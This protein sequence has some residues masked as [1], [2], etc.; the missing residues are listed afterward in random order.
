MMT[1]AEQTPIDIH[2]LTRRFGGHVAVDGLSLAVQ[3][4]EIFGLIGSNG[5]GKS[6]LIKMLTTLLPPSAGSARVAGYDIVSQPAQVRRRIGYVPQLM[7]SDGSLT[8]NENMTLSAR[9]YG[10]PRA[11]RRRRIADALSRMGLGGDA[12][13]LVSGFSGGMIRRLEIAQS[14]LHRPAVLFLDEPTVG[15]DPA[16]RDAVWD[17]VLE[18]QKEF[19]T[20]LVVTSHH[21][22]E[23]NEF[24]DRVALLDYGRIVAM[25]TPAELRS[26]V[27]PNATLDDLFIKLVGTKADAE[28]GRGYVNA[29]LARRAATDRG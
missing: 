28:G 19:G 8:A 9:L 12:D 27:G 6:T 10:I 24:C 20:T 25:G 18:L 4:G 29:R 14:L 17:H 16:A 22:E 26:R 1:P 2:D 21:L 5:A 11:E 15:L 23:I 13:R 7:S 3:S